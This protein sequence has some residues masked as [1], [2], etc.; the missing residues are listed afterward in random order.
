VDK[1]D[2]KLWGSQFYEGGDKYFVASLSTLVLSP[3]P[4][5]TFKMKVRVPKI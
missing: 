1:I 4:F 3:S 2:L 5:G